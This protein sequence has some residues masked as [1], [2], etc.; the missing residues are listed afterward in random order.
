MRTPRQLPFLLPLLFGAAVACGTVPSE[1]QPPPAG[2]LFPPAGVIR[3]TVVYNGVRPCS[4]NGHIVGNAL[5]LVFNR[6]NLPPPN[7]LANTVV[8]FGVVTGDVLFASEPR[9]TG[10]DVYCPAQKGFTDTITVSGPFAISPLDAGQYVIES[11]FDYTGDFLPEFK[12]RNLPEQG[13]VAGGDIDT[14]DA[15]KAVNAGNPNYQPRFLPVE[16]GTPQPLD[17]ALPS[18]TVP[19]YTMPSNGFVADNVTVTI[20]ASIPTTRPYF[21]AQ[22]LKVVFDPNNPATITTTPVQSSEQ[23]AQSVNGIDG[24][25]E[26]SQ[27]YAPVLT[28]PQDL[29]VLAPPRAI[30]P[31]NAN[32]FESV[33]PHLRLQ[34]GLPGAEQSIAAAPDKPFH[35]QVQAPS[36][37][38]W[39]NAVLNPATQQWTP[40]QI[41]EG[42]GAPYL[43]PFVVLN[44][45]VDDPM[46][47]SD[48]TSVT[49][50]GS[51]SAPA[52]ILLGIT[53][54]GD[55]MQT[56][57]ESLFTT[58]FANLG[59]ALFNAKTGTPTIFAQNHVTVLLRPS[60]IC[61]D[62]F[63]DPSKPDKRGTLVTPHLTGTTADLGGGTPNQPVVPPDLLNNP[64]LA[65]LVKGPPIEACL[66]T[67]RYAINAVYPDGQAWTVPNESGSCTTSE[68]L[69]DFLNHRCGVAGLPAKPRDILYSQGNRAVVEV[70]AAKDPTHCQ[71]AAA[72]PAACL[73]Y[74]Q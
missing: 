24:S 58:V 36:L 64:Q 6:N 15:L 41:P 65:A 42:N 20:G 8:N 72:V 33:F 56:G 57:P 12:I 22:G 48:P 26:Q 18:F 45:L 73:P 17:P 61:F 32:Y 55:N 3:G 59:G 60:V 68:G 51:V 14:A 7:G 66:P 11:F 16:V 52:V 4:S 25:V 39:Q 62:N 2:R 46:H 29:A 38:V 49:A 44:K 21:Y 37:L 74:P 27:D 53:L 13:D 40:L 43:W 35:F 1:T 10:A 28:M 69:T 63:F 19:T 34:A 67:G 5:V 30:N 31:N 70:V 54:L 50:Q 23:G 71:G 47:T 9:Y